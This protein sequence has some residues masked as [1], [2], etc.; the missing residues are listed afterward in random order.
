MG[1]QRMWLPRIT[2]TSSTGI[3]S[4]LGLGGLGGGLRSC[5][6]SDRAFWTGF[7]GDKGLEGGERRGLWMRLDGFERHGFGW[8]FSE[9]G[10][11]REWVVNQV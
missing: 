3:N 10:E 5:R 1:A 2:Y 4:R 8:F 9:E 7:R 11:A 6:R